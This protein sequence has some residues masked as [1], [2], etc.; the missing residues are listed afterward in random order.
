MK[1]QLVHPTDA[2]NV[3]E[4]QGISIVSTREEQMSCTCKDAICYKFQIS[5][6]LSPTFL[7]GVEHDKLN[8]SL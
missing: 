5:G 7:N 6:N 2:V 1:S 8:R 4:T 3:S